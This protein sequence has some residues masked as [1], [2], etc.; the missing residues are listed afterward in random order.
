MLTEAYKP[1]FKTWFGHVP[2][3]NLTDCEHIEVIYS[4]FT[5]FR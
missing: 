3:V 5:H 4:F 1:I 2:V